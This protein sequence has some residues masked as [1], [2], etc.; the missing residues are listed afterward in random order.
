MTQT[1]AKACVLDSSKIAITCCR[2]TAGNPSK[3]SSI[4]SPPSKWSNKLLTGTR[5]PVNTGSPPM[6]AGSAVIAFSMEQ[7]LPLSPRPGNLSFF[8]LF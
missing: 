4:D 7:I 2:R 3:K 1:P 6:T 5:V 8:E